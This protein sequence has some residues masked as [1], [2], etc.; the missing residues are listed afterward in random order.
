MRLSGFRGALQATSWR[1]PARPPKALWAERASLA[2]G[3]DR[4]KG[5]EQ[6]GTDDFDFMDDGDAS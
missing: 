5:L 4:G 1:E 3:A 6:F 2:L